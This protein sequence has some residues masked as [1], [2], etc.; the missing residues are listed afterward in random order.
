MCGICISKINYNIKEF[1]SKSLL[2]KINLN[3]DNKNYEDCLI[4]IR[5]LKSNFFFLKIIKN[6]DL[7]LIKSL[8]ELIIKLRKIKTEDQKKFEILKDIIWVIESELLFKCEKISSFLKKNKISITTKSI[9]F[10]RFLL[11]TFES[12]NYL[13]SRGRD[14]FG[15]SINFVSKKKV[16]LLSKYKFL[17]N[18]KISLIQK[19]IDN[20]FLINVTFK[21]SKRVGYSGENTEEIIKKIF[22]SKILSKIDFNEII[23]TDLFAHTRWAS[24]GEVNLSNTHPVLD[25]KFNEFNLSMMN[26]DI[27]NYQNIVDELKKKNKYQLNDKNCSNDLLPI[28]S[29]VFNKYSDINSKLN[30]SYVLVNFNSKDVTKF[31]LFKKGTQG[32]YLAFDED[33]NIHFASDVYGLVNKSNKIIKFDKDGEYIIDKNFKNKHH[34]KNYF[35]SDLMTNDLSKKGFEGFFLKEINDTELFLKRTINNYINFNNNN[36]KNLNNIFDNKTIS[37]FKYKKIKNIIFT[38][39]GSCYSAAVGIS[40]YLNKKL[41]NVNFK[42]I[43]VE[44]TVASEGSG[45]YL[46]D[47]MEDTIIIVLA[48]SGTTIDTNVFAKLAKEKGAYT[49]AIVN[50]KE[51]DVTF[52][53]EKSFYLGNGRDVEMS[54]P[55]TKTYTCH[56]LMGFI[57]SE[58]IIELVNSKKNLDFFKQNKEIIRKNYI[59]KKYENLNQHIETL[60]IDIFKFKNWIVLFDDSENSFTALELRIKISECCYKSVPYFNLK[61]FDLKKF[62]NTLMFYVGSKKINLKNLNN[63]IFFISISNANMTNKKNV[64]NI[65]LKETN[66]FKLIIE[67]SLALQILSYKISTLIDKPSTKLLSDKNLNKIINFLINDHEKNDFLKNNLIS[68]KKILSEKLKRPIDAIKHQAKTVTVGATRSVIIDNDENNNLDYFKFTKESI[69][70]FRELFLK[71]K[72]KISIVGEIKN[73][74]YKYFIGNLIEYYNHLYKKEYHFKIFDNETNFNTKK[75]DLVIELIKNK[76]LVKNKKKLISSQKFNYSEDLILNFLPNNNNSQKDY[77]DFYNAKK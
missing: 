2:N 16:V 24:V 49:L 17:N 9:I 53:V 52:I 18:S 10:T 31:S 50:K 30:G 77:I 22:H 11:Y 46:S 74:I 12:I 44:A 20:K 14:S 28:S 55:S 43:K 1:N 66:F 56:L 69:P 32:L 41:E 70:E 65:I 35:L 67:T 21:F 57:L 13:E 51:G 40:K 7:I 25:K 63:S 37:K 48:Q 19:K 62:N 4:L 72:N 38:G 68:Q 42:D 5:Q 60:K 36:F 39:M 6:K 15:L 58:K 47:N 29:L 45:F 3:L 73:D 54:V 27:N 61:N 59:S 64:Y 8:N 33:E 23:S 71:F 34:S 26:G 75:D 76:V